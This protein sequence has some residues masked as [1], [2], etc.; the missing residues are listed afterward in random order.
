MLTRR[1]LL[2]SGAAA[3]ASSLAL[4]ALAQGRPIKIGYVSPQSGPLSAF[5]EADNYMIAQFIKTAADQSLNV[6]VVVKDSQSN[7]NRAADVARELI[8][9]DEVNLICVAS[10][11]ETTNPVCTIAEA[12][13]VPVISSVAPWQPWFIGQQGNPGDPATWQEFDYVH[14]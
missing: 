1:N 10:T 14:H 9:R 7:P 11:P 13:E 8:V 6:E 4:P 2:K 5:S 12:E 3:A